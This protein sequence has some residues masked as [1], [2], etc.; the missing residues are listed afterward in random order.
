[1]GRELLVHEQPTYAEMG[2]DGVFNFTCGEHV[3]CFVDCCC[4][5]RIWLY[6]Y[7]VLRISR[8]LGLTT[9]EL[10]Q[11]YCKFFEPD[12]A[13]F[14]VLLFKSADEGK[15]RC[16][17]AEDS[18]CRIYPER[19]WI[20]R[21]FPVIPVEC[22]TDLTPKA[23]RR[24]NV[25]VWEGCRGV[26][27]GPAVTIEEWWQRAGMAAYEESYP[28]WQLLLE[29]LKSSG[30]LP[31]PA[32]AAEQFILGSFD[33]DRFRDKLLGGE[34]RDVLPLDEAELELAAND[35]IFLLQVACRWLR[36]VLFLQP[37]AGYSP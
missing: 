36:R 24:F 33:L 32:E 35:D 23:E 11:Q 31:L 7:D 20:C 25:L 18:G 4:G 15:G 3:S 14:P 12:E 2:F 19:P 6:P 10:L 28:T 26:G 17:F 5:T 22:R 13:G 8:L 21:L 37:V 34:L 1:M 9:T 27:C 30:S 29:D 16:P